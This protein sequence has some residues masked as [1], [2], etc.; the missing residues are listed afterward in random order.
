MI[1]SEVDKM[2]AHYLYGSPGSA[3]AM[4]REGKESGIRV[5]RLPYP[6]SA[7]DYWSSRVVKSKKTGK[8]IV[9]T[10]VT[11][12]ARAYKQE[13]GYLALAAGIRKP[14][15]GRVF[16][17]IRLF[18]RRPQDWLKRM[19]KDPDGW[20]DTVQCLDLD[21]ARKVLYDAL[22]G[23]AFVDDKWIKRDGGEICEP[24]EHGARVEVTLGPILTP[25]IAPELPL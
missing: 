7:N 12:E 8:P 16:V 13:I 24:D 10:F 23:I 1:I 15:E 18:P 11:D 19:Q 14:I 20:A 5:L 2:V 21:N 6:V 9:L 4:A 3:V 25:K 17:N 22:K